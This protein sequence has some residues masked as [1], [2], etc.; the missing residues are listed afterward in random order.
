MKIFYDND[1]DGCAA[2]WIIKK[3]LENKIL[4]TKEKISFEPVGYEDG[5]PIDSIQPK[6]TVFILDYSIPTEDMKKLLNKTT[7]VYWIDHH[8]SAIEMYKEF[9]F[10]IKGLR[11]MEYSTC[12]NVFRFIF[13]EKYPIPKVIKLVGDYDIWREGFEKE[14]LPFVSGIQIFD[15][16]PTKG[17]WE[18][19]DENPER[20]IT[21]GKVIEMHKK[22]EY[23]SL[24]PKM[25]EAEL[26]GLK[27]L[28][29]NAPIRGA[30]VFKGHPKENESD[31]RVLYHFN[32]TNYSFSIFSTK[33]D[34]SEIAAKY[35]GGGH[36]EAAGFVY[37]K[38]P[39]KV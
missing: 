39:F 18:K 5:L 3:A 29:L 33:H 28:V 36:K 26:K 37:D 9:P 11:D 38:L 23:K 10:E 30:F 20:Y 24:Q 12:E 6:E 27:C 21:I 35:G 14:A 25:Y 32:G 34:V 8:K 22:E 4:H 15:L 2:S 1:P 19:F 31:L 13:K 7:N 17:N 16:D